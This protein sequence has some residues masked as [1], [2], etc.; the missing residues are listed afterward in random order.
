M[1]PGA[2]SLRVTLVANEC[3]DSQS[4]T[5]L[6]TP[7]QPKERPSIAEKSENKSPGAVVA[8]RQFNAAAAHP[9]AALASKP[10]SEGAGK[11]AAGKAVQPASFKPG[12]AS[13]GAQAFSGCPSSVDTVHDS[14]VCNAAY[15]ANECGKDCAPITSPDCIA[16]ERQFPETVET[17]DCDVAGG[18]AESGPGA[19]VPRAVLCRKTLECLRTTNCALDN[20]LECFCGSEMG[21]DCFSGRAKRP[22]S[23]SD[24][25]RAR[26]ELRLGN[27]DALRGREVRSRRGHPARDQRSG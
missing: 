9:G 5:V 11:E 20:V 23:S 2:T 1:T 27:R 10:T 3:T 6:C 12:S 15:S 14:E 21:E 18:M 24:R 26:N 17:A 25:G 8:N 19:G 7:P 4:L 22:V 13:L 16:C